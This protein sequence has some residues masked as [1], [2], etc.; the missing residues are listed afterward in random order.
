MIALVGL[1]LCVPVSV[2]LSTWL[3]AKRETLTFKVIESSAHIADQA[4]ISDAICRESTEHSLKAIVALRDSLATVRRVLKA[5][6][7]R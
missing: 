1:I 3:S 4:E 6:G 2:G 7:G 5:R